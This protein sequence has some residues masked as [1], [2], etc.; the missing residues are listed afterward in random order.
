MRAGTN[1]MEP[2]SRHTLS[3]RLDFT[4]DTIVSLLNISILLAIDAY[5]QIV[6]INNNAA[7]KKDLPN[8]SPD[9]KKDIDPTCQ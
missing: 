1:T 8:K 6:E 2:T 4:T 5:I 9:E 3:I 7:T